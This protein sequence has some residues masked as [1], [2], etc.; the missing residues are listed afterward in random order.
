VTTYT[1][2]ITLYDAAFFGMLFVCFTFILLLWFGKVNRSANRFLAVALAVVALWIARVLAIDIRLEKYLAHWDWLP[3][4]FLLA[5]GPLIYFYVLKITRPDYKFRLKDLLHFSPLL[6]EIGVLMTEIIESNQTGRSTYNTASFQHLNPVLQLLIFISLIVYLY[7]SY[8]LIENFYRRLRPVMMD[9]SRLEFR[10]LRR[11]L[12]ATAVLWVLWMVYAAIDFLGYSNQPGI[13]SYY[14]V[15]IFFAAIMIWT[16]AAAFLKPQAALLVQPATVKAPLSNEL[17]Q[18]GTWLKRMM[19][20]NRY[21]QDPDL[22]LNSLAEKLNL[23]PHELSRIINTAVKKSFNDFINE[24]RIIDVISKMQDPAYDHITLLGIAYDSGFNSKSA[25]HRVF[26]ARTGKSPAEYKTQLKKEL[27]SYNLGQYPRS[28]AIISN[29]ETMPQWSQQKLNRNYMFKNYFKTAWR[30]LW[31]Q[32]AF[33]TINVLGL[34]IGISASLVIYL[35]ASYDLSFD[36]FERDNNR[37]YRVV[38]AYVFSGE[39]AYNSGVAVPTAPAIKTELTGLDAVV[40]FFTFNDNPKISIPL[41]DQT[42]PA[43]FKNQSGFIYADENYFNLVGYSWLAGA[44]NTALK[45]P[46]QAV[47]TQ[48]AAALYFPKLQPGQILG[49]QFHMNDTVTVTVTGVVG[50]IKANTDLTFKAF[51]SK[52][53]LEIARFRPAYYNDWTTTNGG[54]QLFVKLQEGASVEKLQKEMTALYFRNNPKKPGENYEFNYVLQ[55]LADIHFNS[56]YGTYSIP[57]VST[58]VLLGLLSVALFL[59]LLGCINF[60][61]LTTAQSAQRAKEIGIRKTIGGSK[62]QLIVQFLSESFL[63]TLIATALSVGLT[64]VI[65]KAFSGFIPAAVTFNVLQ[66]PRIF[67]FLVILLIIVTLLSGFYPA[68]VLS[69]YKPASVLKNQISKSTSA[70]RNA[71]LRKILTV[72]QF[73]IAQFFIMA[74]ILVGKQISYSLHKDM[75]FKKDAIVYFGLYNN[76]TAKSRRAALL[77]ALHSIPEITMVSLSSNPPSSGGA[78]INEIG[79]KDGKKETKT[80]VIVRNADTNYIK[81]YGIKLLAGNN[82]SASDARNNVLINETGLHVLGFHDPHDAVGKTITWDD[83]PALV[84]GV[85]KDFNQ[86][87]LHEPIKPLLIA[88]DPA[89]EGLVNLLLRPQ[90]V[91]GTS[92]QTALEKAKQAFKSA[93]PDNDTYYGFFDDDIAKYY[94]EEQNTSNLLNWAT[95]LSVFISC[96]GLLGLVIFTTTQRTKEIGIRKVLGATVAQITALISKDFLGLV[97]I[98]FVIAAP[99]AWIGMDKWL[100]SFAF[101]TAVSWWIFAAAALLMLVIA[102]ITLSFQA[103][104]AALSNPVKSLRTE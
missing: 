86:R 13:H 99:L 42:Q 104:R 66:Q 23:G 49:R 38:S 18:K 43:V 3:M 85:V 20:D 75:G 65:L 15:Y 53:T 93:Y 69:S 52:P 80:E 39:K 102:L 14:P 81:L 90:N 92:W 40:P 36:K 57:Q 25:F 60:V 88:N 55:P 62:K 30:T 96:L 47:L 41:A 5:L 100:Q 50:D 29:H 35:V 33:S 98:A 94:K 72:T 76:D 21:H 8:Q 73:A 4:Q 84:R 34:A 58:T 97:L 59:L 19:V 17:K 103:V 74:T 1:F 46:Y 67:L 77:N 26:K 16:A 63:L 64:P 54:S 6:L 27:P 31:K 45:Q 7:K 28:A 68:V 61:N 89:N 79:Y 32:K 91:R 9:R 83:K 51:V 2:H 44:A 12:V 70:T 24:Y 56:N 101:R 37:I 78:Q 87:S 95:V 48:S 10:W 11:L 22:S 71:L 82:L